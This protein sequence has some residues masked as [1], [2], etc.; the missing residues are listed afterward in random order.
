MNGL[1][2]LAAAARERNRALAEKRNPAIAEL[3]RRIAELEG[4]LAGA[5]ERGD[6]LAAAL[7]EALA[8]SGAAPADGGSRAPDGAQGARPAPAKRRGR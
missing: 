7:A 6:A 4:L 3:K 2:E 8:K 5:V 1:A